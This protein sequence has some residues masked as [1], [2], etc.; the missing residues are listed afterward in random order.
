MLS[1]SPIVTAS[2]EISTAGQAPQMP[3]FS[4]TLVSFNPSMFKLLQSLA[5]PRYAGQH[6]AGIIDL[7]P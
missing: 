7:E 4:T 2:D 5:A 6:L 1:S 3:Q